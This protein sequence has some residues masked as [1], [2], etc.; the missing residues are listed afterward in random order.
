[1]IGIL[2]GMG[3][4]TTAPFVDFVVTECYTQLGAKY[5]LD[6][7][8]MMI[9]S[10]PVPF[11]IDRPVDH[12]ALRETVRGGL[13]R[14]EA[15]GVDLIAMPCN[16][17]HVY[18]DHL[19]AAIQVPL[20]NMIDE[21]LAEIP[22]AARRAAILGTRITIESGLY[23]AGLEMRGIEAI[24]GEPWQAHT[25][26]LISQVKS[27]P[28]LQALERDWRS[29]VERLMNAG[30]DTVI[31]GCSELT[32]AAGAG[33]TM[34]SSQD[35]GRDSVRVVDPTRSLARATVATWKAGSRSGSA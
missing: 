29:L 30:V 16:T 25:D 33:T 3:P 12:D 34:E 35:P 15:T 7:P 24:S 21:A 5:D 4:R 6:F 8:P 18:Y 26:D 28:D 19:A 2:A 14:L 31:L 27:A 17:V 20:L 13:R 1:M 22:A 10:L 32:I 9:H 11:W 23:Q